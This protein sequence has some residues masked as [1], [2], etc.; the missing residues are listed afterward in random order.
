MPSGVQMQVTKISEL[1][2]CVCESDP[3][4]SSMSESDLHTCMWSEACALYA[5]VQEDLYLSSASENGV[6]VMA[7]GGRNC[8][9]RYCLTAD[10]LQ[11][12]SAGI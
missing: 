3:A 11:P 8:A 4:K 10:R 9:D 6:T 1:C 2:A 12:P 5:Y 7:K